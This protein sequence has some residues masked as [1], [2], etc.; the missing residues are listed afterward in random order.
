MFVVFHRTNAAGREL[1]AA[2]GFSGSRGQVYTAMAAV[3]DVDNIRAVMSDGSTH[4]VTALLGW[5]RRGQ[6]AVASALTS[7]SGEGIAI[8]PD[9]ATAVGDRCFSMEGGV[10]GGRSLLEGT[11]TGKTV[12]NDAAPLTLLA[13]FLNGTGTPGA[14]VLNEFGELIG[15]ITGGAPGVTR[16][17][18]IMQARAQLRGVPVVP[19]SVVRLNPGASSVPLSELRARGDLLVALSGEQHVLSGGFA[20]S[21]PK[22]P[23]AAP[24]EQRSDFSTQEK[25]LRGL[26]DLEPAR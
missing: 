1:D 16:L 19:L 12:A 3:D 26:P 18:D 15:L 22:S 14:P 17:V 8:A 23:A 7:G 6:W 11:I 21:I 25:E 9:S 13:A 20:R 10:S 2:A 4:S 24:Q 5:H